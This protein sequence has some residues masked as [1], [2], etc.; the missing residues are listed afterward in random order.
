MVGIDVGTTSAKAVVFDVDGTPLARAEQGYPLRAPAPGHAVQDPETVVD[1]V[2]DVT[3]RVLDTARHDGTPVAGLALSGAMHTLIALDE[4][5]RPLTPLVTWADARAVAQAARLRAERPGLHA[6]TGTPL[7]PMSPLVKLVWFSEHEPEVCARA[8]R[9]CGV[10][11]LVLRRLTGTWATDHSTAS[12]TGLLDLQALAWDPEALA[13]AG[14]TADQLCPL[15][16]PT[17]VL[18]AREPSWPPVVAGAADG[19]L[20]NLGVGAI[21][22]GVAACS[23]GT[24]GALRLVAGQPGI[25]EQGRTFCYALTPG[26][27]VVGGAVNNGG[28]VLRWAGDAL[29]PD[30]GPDA[31]DALLRLAAQAP[32]GSDGLLMVP[33]LLGERAPSWDAEARG[34]FVGLTI[35]HRRE[36][37]LRAAVEGVCLQLGLV[38]DALR[39]AGHD[40]REI[41]ATGGALRSPV[42]R[43][44]LCDVLGLPLR[45]P[46]GRDGSALG[47]ALLGFA[48][49]G[50]GAPLED[51]VAALPAGD[52]LEPDPAAAAIYAAIR[53]RFA[54]LHEA[55]G[56][57]TPAESRDSQ[58]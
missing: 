21:A 57:R 33:A 55:L 3:R 36:H 12:G 56:A 7:H 39:D 20:A 27:W 19:P 9:W 8:A 29:A 46:A 16:S 5:D 54:A 52:P 53:P 34:A 31:H 13:V 48:A 40:I 32:P 49:L 1:A 25:D 42:W 28:V 17:A 4:D 50:A 45:V 51:A 24:S 37:L 41:R 30:L 15:V 10:K 38:L 22:P 14:V 43:Q 18:E 35:A 6:R 11:E 26:R 58:H 23:I 2:L 44:I 47:A